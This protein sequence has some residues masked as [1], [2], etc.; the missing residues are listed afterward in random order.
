MSY[1]YFEVVFIFLI[2]EVIMILY[3]GLIFC[4]HL[5]SFYRLHCWHCL[6][7]QASLPFLCHLDLLDYNYTWECHLRIVSFWWC[8]QFWGCPHLYGI[9]FVLI[10]LYFE[11]IFIFWDC[12]HFWGDWYRGPKWRRF[13]KPF[14]CGFIW[15]LSFF[16]SSI[17]TPGMIIQGHSHRDAWQS[18]II[19]HRTIPTYIFSYSVW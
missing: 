14:S 2:F 12:L 18:Q 8:F 16:E 1:Q 4:V 11:L 6:H 13:C 10:Y 9:N 5:N 7:F 17:I 15:H 19:R 3:I